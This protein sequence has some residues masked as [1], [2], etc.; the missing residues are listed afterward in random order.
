MS[1]FTLANA[2]PGK[3]ATDESMPAPTKIP[4]VSMLKK[5]APR[6]RPERVT[7]NGPLNLVVFKYSDRAMGLLPQFES[8]ADTPLYQIQCEHNARPSVTVNIV[9]QFSSSYNRAP[10]FTFVCCGA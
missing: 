5:E 2:S 9:A 1:K 4:K 10:D 8:D 7:T 6:E 3:R